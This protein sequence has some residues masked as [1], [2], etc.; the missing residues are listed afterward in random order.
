MPFPDWNLPHCTPIIYVR[1]HVH[2]DSDN[3]VVANIISTN[4]IHVG[5]RNVIS[6][7]L[8]GSKVK[9][10]DDNVITLNPY[11]C[12]DD[13]ACPSAYVTLRICWGW[14][15]RSDLGLFTDGSFVLGSCCA[16]LNF[17]A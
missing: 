15:Q 10:R 13:I 11:D 17:F 8:V 12:Y 5:K 14:L 4:R 2:I 3:T 1:G 16:K 9:I 6:G 7:Q